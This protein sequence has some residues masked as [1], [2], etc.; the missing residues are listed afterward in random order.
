MRL[1]E[2]RGYIY[3]HLDLLEGPTQTKASTKTMNSPNYGFSIGGK[4]KHH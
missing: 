1:Y 4:K 3:I 2:D